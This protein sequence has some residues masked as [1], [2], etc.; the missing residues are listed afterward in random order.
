LFSNILAMDELKIIQQLENR[1]SLYFLFYFGPEISQKKRKFM[2]RLK[3][4]SRDVEARG[5]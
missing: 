5:M 1:Y 2:E 4:D 3:F